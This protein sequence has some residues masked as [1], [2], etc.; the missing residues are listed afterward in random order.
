MKI[1]AQKKKKKEGK[2][3]NYCGATEDEVENIEDC[4]REREITP[5]SNW[6]QTE[7]YLRMHLTSDPFFIITIIIARDIESSMNKDCLA[8]KKCE[9][10]F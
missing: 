7:N 3:A 6:K 2:N 5:T 4:S 10:K 1:T 8:R 9:A